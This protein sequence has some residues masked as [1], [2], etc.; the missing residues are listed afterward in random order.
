MRELNSDIAQVKIKSQHS[1]KHDVL[2]EGTSITILLN[3]I[4]LKKSRKHLHMTRNTVL[5]CDILENLIK[6]FNLGSF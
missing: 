1:G 5:P 2:E 6:L 3:Q 4:N